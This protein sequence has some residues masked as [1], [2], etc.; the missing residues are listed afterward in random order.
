LARETQI[1]HFL[2]SWKLGIVVGDVIYQFIE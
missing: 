1:L 2:V